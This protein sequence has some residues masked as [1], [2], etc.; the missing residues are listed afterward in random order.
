[1]RFTRLIIGFLIIVVA[2]LIIAGEQ[3]S[4][5]SGDAVINARINEPPEN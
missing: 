5:A 2:L 1:M 4:G 3:L